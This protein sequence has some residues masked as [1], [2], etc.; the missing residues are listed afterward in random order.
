MRA[1]LISMARLPPPTHPAC[2]C[3][4]PPPGADPGCWERTMID[5]ARTWPSDLESLLAPI[6]PARPA[7]TSLRYEDAYDRIKEARRADDP[8]L[9]QGVWETELKRADWPTVQ[10]LCMEA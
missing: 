6:S 5:Q 9:P 4:P 10:E 8:S 2:R 3:R 7:R 1:R